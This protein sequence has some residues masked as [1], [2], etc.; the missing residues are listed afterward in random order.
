MPRMTRKP[1]I[2]SRMVRNPAKR[3]FSAFPRAWIN[4]PTVRKIDRPMDLGPAPYSLLNSDFPRPVVDA[5]FFH[6][7]WVR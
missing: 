3:G 4:R 2:G 1:E 5:G 7:G 6:F